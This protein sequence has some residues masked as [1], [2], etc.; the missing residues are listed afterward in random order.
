MHMIEDFSGNVLVTSGVQRHFSIN[1][2][3]A[4]HGV[5]DGVRQ[6]LNGIH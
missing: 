2:L 6:T 4:L 5:H 1:V 3:V